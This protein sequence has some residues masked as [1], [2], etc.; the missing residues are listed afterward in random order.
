MTKKS[1]RK[2]NVLYVSSCLSVQFPLIYGGS[3]CFFRCTIAQRTEKINLLWIKFLKKLSTSKPR[4]WAINQVIG[5]ETYNACFFQNFEAHRH[6]MENTKL[7]ILTIEYLAHN[8]RSLKVNAQLNQLRGKLMFWAVSRSRQQKF[9]DFPWAT[10]PLFHSDKQNGPEDIF[11]YYPWQT[12]KTAV[13]SVIT[14]SLI[15]ILIAN[16]GSVVPET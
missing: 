14:S 6:C 16:C 11:S 9:E 13:R 2:T 3:C 8:H 15:K 5:M 1:D 4:R 10:V 12:H 7:M